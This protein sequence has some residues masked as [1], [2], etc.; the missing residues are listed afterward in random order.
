MKI[1]DN[2]YQLIKK[3][4]DTASR[5]QETISSNIANVNTPGFKASKVRFEEELKRAMGTG[6]L[7]LSQTDRQHVGP[8]NI[9][10][11]HP[12]VVRDNAHAMD[13]TG[14]N[15]DLD[16]E[17]VDMA[18]NEIYQSALVEQLNKKLAI[19]NYVINR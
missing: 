3:G 13:E 12:E 10:Q 15:V 9:E 1:S 16:R 19:M 18:A 5:R 14:N 2:S 8:G 17:M 11:V 7:G 4:L 6:E